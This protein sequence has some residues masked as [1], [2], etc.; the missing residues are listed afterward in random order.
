MN[1]K[2]NAVAPGS[3][4]W[5]NH[6]DNLMSYIKL[7]YNVVHAMRIYFQASI[8]NGRKVTEGGN[9]VATG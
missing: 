6:P 7:Q 3:L 2:R 8:N 1:P 9:N 5:Y 4:V